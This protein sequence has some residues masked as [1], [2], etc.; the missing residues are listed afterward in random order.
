MDAVANGLSSWLCAGNWC[1]VEQN[2][3]SQGIWSEC[4]GTTTGTRIRVV[5]TCRVAAVSIGRPYVAM[6]RQE[7][8]TR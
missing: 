3:T 1:W 2:S 6:W 4:Q 5:G 7:Q 8:E